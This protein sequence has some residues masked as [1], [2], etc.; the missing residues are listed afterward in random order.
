[1]RAGLPITV[2]TCTHYLTF[3]AEDVPDEATWWK[4]APPLRAKLRQDKLW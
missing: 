3:A 1:M 2:E 4:C